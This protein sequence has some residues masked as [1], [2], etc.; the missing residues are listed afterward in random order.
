MPNNTA[1]LQNLLDRVRQRADMEGSTFVTEAEITTYINVAMAE[2]HDVLVQRYED[3]YVN[4]TTFTLPTD[5]P[6]TLPSSFYKAL[7]VDFD[8]GGVTHRL[9][10]YKFQE[11]NMFNSPAL[12]AGRVTSTRYAI[13]GSQIKFIPDPAASGTVTLYY[14]PESQQFTASE[15]STTLVSIAPQVA[16]GYEEYIVI[17]AAI[18]CLQKEESEVT[19]LLAQKEQLR[20]RI[21]DAAMNRDAGEPSVISDVSIG[22][23]A[24]LF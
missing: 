16:R 14:V 20:A 2:L 11:R 15:A 18:K 24:H 22:T 4:S 3:Y 13:Q 10:R 1:T 21:K 12:V 8:S 5:N 9:Q 17:D 6:G 23:Y 7:G 19:I